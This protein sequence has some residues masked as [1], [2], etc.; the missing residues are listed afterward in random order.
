MSKM[1]LNI[2]KV[3]NIDFD[4]LNEICVK[5]FPKDDAIDIVSSLYQMEHF[6]VAELGKEQI[7]VGFVVFG[8]YS[9]RI[10]HIMIL[11]VHPE[12]QRLS[13]GSDLLEFA[14]GIIKKEYVTKIRLEVRIENDVA[15]KFYEH[16]NFTNMGILEDYYDD[17]SNA[18]LMV[19]ELEYPKKEK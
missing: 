9:L 7:I 16:F 5:G 14:L 10:A 13:I 11:A 4:R 18:Y 2:R 15:I 12:Y 1:K 8:I 3:S 6:Y 17:G 19:R